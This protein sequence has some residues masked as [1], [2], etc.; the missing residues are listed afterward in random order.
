MDKNNWNDK[1]Y[2]LYINSGKESLG[3][4]YL[5]IKVAL[6]KSKKLDRQLISGQI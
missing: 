3:E 1:K 6:I 2:L 4:Y 5:L